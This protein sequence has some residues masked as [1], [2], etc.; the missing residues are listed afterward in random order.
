VTPPRATRIDRTKLRAALRKLGDEYVYFMLDEALDLLPEAKL[1]K[2]VGQYIDLKR[3]QSDRSPSKDIFALVKEFERA[4][5]AG[6]FYESFNV[7]SKNFTQLANGTRA[8][9]AECRRLL[10]QLVVAANKARPEDVVV[11][12]ESIFRV[13][14]HVDQGDDDV[15][16]FADE[17]GVW[18]VGVEWRKVFPAWFT[19]LSR[20]ASP[21]DYAERVIEMVDDL[22][23]VDRKIHLRAAGDAATAAQRKALAARARSA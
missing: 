20:V 15:V 12:F 8:W 3:L 7:N 4:S 13:L 2:L 18:L 16:F 23:E 1:A 5:L 10:D 19:C 21:V 17:G 22:D 11:G 9:I 14:H 6:E